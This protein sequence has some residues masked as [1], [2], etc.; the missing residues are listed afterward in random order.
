VL[1]VAT[2][3]AAWALVFGQPSRLEM[4][5]KQEILRFSRDDAILFFWSLTGVCEF[6]IG[7]CGVCLFLLH[8]FFV[9]AVVIFDHIEVFWWCVLVVRYYV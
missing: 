9:R 2:P 6:N 1:V 5:L 4:H 3:T 8:F 7:V